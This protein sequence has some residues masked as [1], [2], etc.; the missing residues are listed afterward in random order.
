M[1][2][3]DR[4]SDEYSSGK[5]GHFKVAHVKIN[6][7]ELFRDFL[8]TYKHATPSGVRMKW[9]KMTAAINHV[10]RAPAIKFHPYYFVLGFTFP[11]PHL[12]Q[13]VICSMKCAPAQCSPNAVRTMV[14]VSNLSRFFDLG[15]TINEFW[16]F[17]KIGHKEGVWQLRSRHKLLDASCKCDH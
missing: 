17:F 2:S 14:G 12:F 10:V 15:L 5:V 11:M 8:E 6:S 9:V 4:K 1:S 13:E 7:D 3:S 16:Y